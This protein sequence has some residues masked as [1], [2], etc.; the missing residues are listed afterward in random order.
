MD[1]IIGFFAD[2]GA[3]LSWMGGLSFLMFV[4]SL[5]AVPMAIARLPEDYLH[6]NHKLLK[7]WPLYLSALFLI[8]KNILG[9]VFLISGM[10]MLILPGQG[11]LT[12][13]IGLAM[14][15]FPRKNILIRR[16]MGHKR[17]F[18]TINQ[19]RVKLGKPE[20]ESP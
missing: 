12:L 4:V 16:I 17:I 13:I 14:I 7:D 10:A 1:A 8:F 20:L 2:H 5:I 18:P 6:R 9:V 11:L 19:I 15:D 3:L